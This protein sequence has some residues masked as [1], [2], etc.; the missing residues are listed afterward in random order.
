MIATTP[1][2]PVVST[3]PTRMSYAFTHTINARSPTIFCLTAF[4]SYSWNNP[5]GRTV[6]WDEVE[7]FLKRLTTMGNLLAVQRED[8]KWLLFGGSILVFHSRKLS[9]AD[10][11]AFA[12]SG[13]YMAYQVD[14][15]EVPRDLANFYGTSDFR[16]LADVHQRDFL[17]ELAEL[18]H[19]PY[20]TEPVNLHDRRFPYHLDELKFK[21]VDTEIPALYFIHQRDLLPFPASVLLVTRLPVCDYCSCY[22]L[23]RKPRSMRLDAYCWATPAGSAYYYWQDGAPFKRLRCK[24]PVKGIEPWW[25][26]L[27]E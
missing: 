8:G 18:V 12:K 15:R 13:L 26:Q 2:L 7:T 25:Q 11:V 4:T 21:L 20:S 27:L 24:C 19:N 9:K 10:L 17:L 22:L 5:Q 1:A 3:V 6:P 23:V 16:S 14:S